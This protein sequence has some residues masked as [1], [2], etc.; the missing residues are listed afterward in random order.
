[1]M[2]RKLFLPVGIGVA[3]FLASCSKKEETPPVPTVTIENLKVAHACAFKRSEWY[4]AA[5]KEADRERFGNLAALFRAISKSESVHASL[6]EQLL[7]SRNQG[8]DTSKA[9][10]LP[11]GTALQALKMASSLERTEFEGLYP[12][13]VSAAER[14]G[15]HEAAQQFRHTAAADS[16]HLALFKVADKRSGTVPKRLYRVCAG[17]GNVVYDLETACAIC[18]GTA[19]EPS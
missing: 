12:P 9:A 14:E 11:L 13:M 5:A 17:C 2:I 16:G 8:T 1:M 4:A 3:V 15:W 18:T 6:H 7:V 10:C 19:F